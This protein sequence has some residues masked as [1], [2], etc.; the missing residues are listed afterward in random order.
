MRKHVSNALLAVAVGTP[1]LLG[2]LEHG[3]GLVLLAC[4]ALG[5][6][7]V[8]LH[9]SYVRFDVPNVPSEEAPAN[10][11]STAAAFVGVADA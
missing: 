6:V 9:P 1:C 8:V 11:T 5:V 10:D 3:G 4:L 2:G 7:G